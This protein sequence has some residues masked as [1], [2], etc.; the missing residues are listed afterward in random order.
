MTNFTYTKLNDLLFI[1]LTYSLSSSIPTWSGKCGFKHAITSDYHD[2]NSKT[3]FRVQAIE[4]HAGIGTH[5]DAPLHC[6]P[7]AP[8]IASLPLNQLIA[9]C[10]M[11]D[12]SAKADENYSVTEE[13]IKQFESQHGTIDKKSL[14]IIHTGWGKF[15]GNPEKYRNNLI[16]PT[17]SISAAEL[18]LKRDL[19]GL[20]IDTLSP[21]NEKEGF[22]VHHLLLNAGKYIIENVANTSNVPAIGATIIA[23][24]IKIQEGTEAPIR[25]IAA[26]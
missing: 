22:P 9:P 25:L 23:L 20:G 13:D 4:I 10:V 2:D 17:V 12:V 24:P 19:V 1:D 14:I 21:D 11:I 6:I 18:L 7:G 8:D 3:K 26:V 5:I 15:W 16:F